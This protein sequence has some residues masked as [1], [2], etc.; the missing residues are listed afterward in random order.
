MALMP[1]ILTSYRRPRVVMRRLLS[2][3]VREDLAL[4]YL[5]LGCAMIFVAQWPRLS[6]EAHLNAEVP[7]NALLGGALLGWLFL[8]PLV[9]YAIG[10]LSH[11]IARAV[12]G[13]GSWY[14]ARLALFW[15][16]LASAPLWLL[17]GLTAGFIGAGPA[18]TITGTAALAAFVF[19]WINS[20]A[21]AERAE[22][23]V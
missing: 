19:I 12:G 16:L 13:Q 20:L 3:G 22:V 15:G 10:A 4:M 17:D 18:R 9:L 6:R 21:E 1:D 14:S 8:A 7:L 11:V 23:A 2:A 5:L